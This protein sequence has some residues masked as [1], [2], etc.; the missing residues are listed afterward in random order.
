[1]FRKQNL[2]LW[3]KYVFDLIQKHFLASKTQ[4]L[5]PQHMFLARLNWETFASA[6]MF[7][8]NISLFPGPK[9]SYRHL[10]RVN[11][12]ATKKVIESPGRRGIFHRF[13]M[14]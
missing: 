11:S 5:L 9:A 12:T 1:M 3:S 8:A 14:L 6:A 4:N 13:S 7:S 2:R 10:L